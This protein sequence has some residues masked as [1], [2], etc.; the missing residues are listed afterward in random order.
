L[1]DQAEARGMGP[2]IGDLGKQTYRERQRRKQEQ[3]ASSKASLTVAP[4]PDESGM[5]SPA[6]SPHYSAVGKNY[7]DFPNMQEVY[8]GNGS[9]TARRS[10]N[11]SRLSAGLSNNG[12]MSAR[13]HLQQPQGFI[14]NGNG[15]GR[16]QMYDS[17]FNSSYHSQYGGNFTLRN[18]EFLDRDSSSSMPTQFQSPSTGQHSV[19]NNGE[20]QQHFSSNQ[21][22]SKMSLA[23]S[24]DILKQHRLKRMIAQE[25]RRASD[26]GLAFAE[27][28]AQVADYDTQLDAIK[29][30]RGANG[31]VNI[32]ILSSSAQRSI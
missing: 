4:S 15:V 32:P 16:L 5:S 25:M 10:V 29:S 21:L 27:S 11:E 28:L 2:D 1:I 12:S 31:N 24:E 6:A 9:Q 8:Q 13:G 26:R 20:N 18:F 22:G 3:R 17:S 23:S 14:K 7:R 19:N 30:A